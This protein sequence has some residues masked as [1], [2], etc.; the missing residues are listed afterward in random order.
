MISERIAVRGFSATW[1]E[2]LPLLTPYFVR[3][4]NAVNVQTMTTDPLFESWAVWP[5]QRQT[6]APDFV[7]EVAIQLARRVHEEG[8][9]VAS[10]D[11]GDATVRDAWVAS[12]RVVDRYEGFAGGRTHP[13][14]GRDFEEAKSLAVNIEA[15]TA[16]LSGLVEYSPLVRGAGILSSCEADLAVGEYL[17]EIKAVDRN[18][19]AKDL[20]Q[21]FVYLALDALDRRRWMKGCLLNPRLATWCRFDVEE[22]VRR[23]SG[24]RPSAEVLPDLIAGMRRDVET[25][26]EF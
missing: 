5:V 6:E 20:K 7:A 14:S 23:L 15:A 17:V 8:R 18:F 25:D 26:A 3:V 12:E 9:P 13:F 22:L 11:E 10:L 2:Q 21:L 4:F 24:G 16:C 1:R 19:A